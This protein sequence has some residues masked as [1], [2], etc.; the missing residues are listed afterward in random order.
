VR[1]ADGDASNT[2]HLDSTPGLRPPGCDVVAADLVPN[3]EC[4]A[5]GSTDL[6]AH[7]LL[8]RIDATSEAATRAIGSRPPASPG[9]ANR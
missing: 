1:G 9:G 2:S 3:E 8:A 6:G 5:M 7:E 4:L